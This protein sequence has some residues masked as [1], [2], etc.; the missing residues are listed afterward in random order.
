VLWAAL[1]ATW[2]L[3]RSLVFERL[4]TALS[5]FLLYLV[6]VSI[7]PSRKEFFTACV[8]A[9]LGG[10]LA[11]GIVY[12]STDTTRSG[13][14]GTLV[15]GTREANPNNVAAALM[16]PFALAIGGYVGLRGV[17]PKV[18]AMTAVGLIGVGVY[19]TGSRKAVLAVVVMIVIFLYRFRER[20]QILVAVA[21]LLALTAAMPQAITDRFA[22][23]F[24]GK[25]TTGSGRT[26]I[27]QVGITALERFGTF[28]AGL[29]N[30]TAVYNITASHG[31][32]LGPRASHNTYLEAWVELGIVGLVLILGALVSH[33]WAVHRTRAQGADQVMLGAIE[34]ACLGMLVIAF[35]GDILWSKGFWLVWILL[36]WATYTG[37]GTDH[38][39]F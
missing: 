2:A 6:A 21:V 24:T 1:S 32:R 29:S 25:D 39:E 11:A 31:P 23:V 18:A 5:L 38:Q 13:V 35:F 12:F 16:L 7:R 28:G 30:Y 8:L 27:W 37:V 33:L 4:P 34:G 14:R 17:L 26:E 10:L 19:V 15:L 3:D 20:R 22:A 36:T 9:V